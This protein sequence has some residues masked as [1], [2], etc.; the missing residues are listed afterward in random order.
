MDR[1][2]WNVLCVEGMGLDGNRE[3]KGDGENLEERG[4]EPARFA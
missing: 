4:S 3:E 2:A 1:Y